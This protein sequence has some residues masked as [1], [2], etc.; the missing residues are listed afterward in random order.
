VIEVGLGGTWDCTNVVDAD[1]SVVTNIS[2][3]HT[4]VLGP[5]LEGIASDKAGI[6]KAGSRAVIGETDL[7]LV[8]GALLPCG[9]AG[10]VEVWVLGT[11]FDCTANRLAVG[12]RMVDLRTPRAIYEE[13]SCRC[14]APTRA[15]TRRAPWPQPRRSSGHPSTRRRRRG[16]RRGLGPRTP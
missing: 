2:F 15:R 4:E 8:G 1:V 11:E 10:A 9:R 7:A 5:T 16:F 14:A 13:V 3:D 12:G 6:I